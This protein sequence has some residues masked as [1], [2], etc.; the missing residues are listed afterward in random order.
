MKRVLLI[1][2]IVLLAGVL[3]WRALWVPP[4]WRALQ[5]WAATAQPGDLLRGNPEL[6]RLTGRLWNPVHTQ[7]GAMRFLYSDNPEYLYNDSYHRVLASMRL[8]AGA[9]AFGVG[10]HHINKHEAKGTPLPGR[11]RIVA[12]LATTAAGPATVRRV[13][14]AYGL[15]YG[16]PV[17][18][19]R[20]CTTAWL[21]RPNVPPASVTVRPGETRVLWE[22]VLTPAQC[23][24]AMFDFTTTRADGL[25][26]ATIYGDADLAHPV[27]APYGLTIGTNSG[28]GPYWKR[29]LRPAPGTPPFDAAD[30]RPANK[31]HFRF[32]KQPPAPGTQYLTD[33]TWDARPDGPG[34]EQIRPKGGAV[35]P[36]KGDYN[37]DYTVEIPVRSSTGR[38][39]RFALFATQRF[40]MFAG[41]VRLA[42]G[43]VVHIPGEAGVLL[44]RG[45][46]GVLL[47]RVT[48]TA[49][50]VYTFHWVL[51]G[52]AYADQDFLLVPLGEES[53][54]GR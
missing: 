45:D 43:R 34:K 36:F 26:I 9:T 21:T 23:I 24:N 25:T 7:T 42:D 29:I 54:R 17:Y 38:P 35:R 48:V 13:A 49:P 28:W 53:P 30:T 32:E 14:G 33:D 22:R 6:S 18:A 31:T 10:L 15:S 39:A 1:S 46:E 50:T 11:L 2:A 4:E 16:M 19:G 44:K 27:Y 51:S 41:A 8:S 12:R 5:A 3:L 37:V 20:A 40:G 47:D 52:G